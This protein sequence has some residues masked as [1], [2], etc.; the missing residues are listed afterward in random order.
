M[1]L[2][3]L[4][5]E[6]EMF[7][8]GVVDSELTL[9][10]EPLIYSLKIAVGSRHHHLQFFRNMKFKSVLRCYFREYKAKTTPVVIIV[11]FYVSPPSSVKIKFA[12][13]R[14]EKTPAVQ[15]YEIADYVL[16]FMEMLHNNL[17]SNYKQIVKVDAEKYYSNNP[18]T[19]FKFMRWENY[20]QVCDTNNTKSKTVVAPLE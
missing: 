13:L 10:G 1:S 14:K 8:A 4:I 16:S 12:D 18:R 3:R 15:S 5:Q 7:R 19:V 17:F 9:P 6:Q 11:R 2:K 20:L